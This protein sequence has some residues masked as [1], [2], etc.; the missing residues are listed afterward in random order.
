MVDIFAFLILMLLF[1][2]PAIVPT[3]ITVMSVKSTEAELSW[4]KMNKDNRVVKGFFRGY[5]VNN[6]K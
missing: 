3:N 5:R 4:P 2:V 6:L 1:E